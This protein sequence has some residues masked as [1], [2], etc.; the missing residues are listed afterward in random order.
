VF[1]NAVGLQLELSTHWSLTLDFTPVFP[2]RHVGIRIGNS[3][4]KEDDGQSLAKAG[5][6]PGFLSKQFI[7]IKD[8]ISPKEC[9]SV[10]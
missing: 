7:L 4:G 5:F 8:A 9:A 3:C 1:A 6:A 10:R 2:L